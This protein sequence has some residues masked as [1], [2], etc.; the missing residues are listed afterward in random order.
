MHASR[1][2]LVLASS[3]G[4]LFFGACS[5]GEPEAAPDP[6]PEETGSSPAIPN[7]QLP[8]KPADL[9]EIL[10][11]LTAST[12]GT[13][14]FPTRHAYDFSILL[15]D[16]ESAPEMTGLG[17]LYLP[18]GAEGPVPAM[19]ILHGS[20]GI[21]EGREHDYA[22]LFAETG[23]AG[24]V[25]DYYLPRGVTPDT[26]YG[27]KTMVATETDVIVD[28]YAALNF[29]ATHPEIDAE[30]IGVIGF[31][32][33]GMGTR[34]TLDDRL[35]TILSPQGNRFA[36]HADFYGPC[37][38]T[39]GHS[40]TTGAPYLAVFGDSDS[41]VD[42][43]ACAQVH[44]AISDAGSP[45]RVEILEGAG[46]AWEN[47]QPRE[48]RPFPY[49]RGCSFTFDPV[50]GN[51]LIDG[52]EAANAPEGA[53][54]N[55]RLNAR[56]QLATYVSDCLFTGYIVGRDEAA[57]AAAKSILMEFLNQHLKD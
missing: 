24:F 16:F 15:N 22:R 7:L 53:D 27:M 31:S 33:G 57:D 11:S 49:V 5:P 20:G 9:P 28:A 48:E 56:T 30:R 1:L 12:A 32:Y 41:S 23:I 10:P 38:Q 14:T 50:T 46:H 29:L 2:R 42:P 13:L 37:H 47:D 35:A 18:E 3:F 51:L 8:P 44:K 25:V 52:A 4:L 21:A 6:A 39:L 34:Y 43:E 17:T 26:P 55:A 40:G 45:L 36:T 19:V 54:L